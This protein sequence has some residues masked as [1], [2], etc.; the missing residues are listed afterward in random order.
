[1]TPCKRKVSRLAL[2]LSSLGISLVASGSS[3]KQLLAGLQHQYDTLPNEQRKRARLTGR[4]LIRTLGSIQAA[5]TSLPYKIVLQEKKVRSAPV[6]SRTKTRAEIFAVISRRWSALTPPCPSCR[7]G[8]GYPKRSWPTREW[9][10]E[11]WARQ[12]DRA[13]LNVYACPVQHGFW[14]L[15]HVG[16]HTPAASK[17]K[18]IYFRSILPSQLQATSIETGEHV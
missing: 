8:N 3:Y 1:M 5:L 14:H 10:D 15:G 12:H 6:A 7:M 16:R 17:S 11:V 9:A 4:S 13:T 18:K 2:Y